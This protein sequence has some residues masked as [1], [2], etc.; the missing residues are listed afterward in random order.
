MAR[1][2]STMVLGIAAVLVA[3]GVAAYLLVGRFDLGPFAAGRASAA[4]GR[5]VT[6]A[7][8][9]VTPGRWITVDLS[10]VQVANVAG[11]SRPAMAELGRLTAEVEAVSLLHGP[12]AVA[13]PPDDR[14][15]VGAAGADGGPYRQLEV[16]TREAGA[17]G[18][19]RQE[20]ALTTLGARVR[21]SGRVEAVD[22]GGR[23][24]A[25]V[26]VSG[27]DIQRLRRAL[28]FGPVPLLGQLD[29]EVVA[30]S[31]GATLNAATRA[32]HVSA[33][34][35]MNGGCTAREVIEMASID[36]RLLFR[37]PKG[38]S[39]VSCLLGAL[40]MRAGVGTVMPLR[41]RAANGAIAGAV[42][43]DLY[44]RWFDLTIGSQ[45]ASTSVFALAS[46]CASA[47]R[48]A[49]RASIRRGG[50]RPAGPCLRPRTIWSSCRPA[51][52]RWPGAA[53]AF[54][55]DDERAAITAKR[56]DIMDQR[57]NVPVPQPGARAKQRLWRVLAIAALIAA[58]FV[59][60]QPFLTAVTWAIILPV[61]AWPGFARLSLALG[62][63]RRVAAAVFVAA[64]ILILPLVLAGM[65]AARRAPAVMQAIEHVEQNGVPGPS[66][67]VSRLPLVGPQL[68]NLWGRVSEQG[69]EALAQ[70]RAEINAAARWLLLR[71]GSFGLTLLQFALANLIAALLLVRADRACALLRAFA[72]RIGGPA[73][74]DLLPLAEH[75]IRA[76][77]CG[78]IRHD[79]VIADDLRAARGDDRLQGVGIDMVRMAVGQRDRRNIRELSRLHPPIDKREFSR[80]EQQP[81]AV[82]REQQ[83]GMDIFLDSHGR[84]PVCSNPQRP[85]R[86]RLRPSRVI[87]S[88]TP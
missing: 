5:P 76:V 10:G 66:D 23:L 63:R 46:R 36:V 38:M 4:L 64:G 15:A 28:G 52:G 41:V 17:G 51:C 34:V 70:Y 58:C 7:G 16:R 73:A 79:L 9:H 84:S 68:D 57:L 14:R 8:L 11:G 13:A 25:D 43:F 29:A 85:H 61:S 83:A 27:A 74:S 55:G 24:S 35:S 21:A 56:G 48:S 88:R 33:V 77:S 82:E 1:R 42:R 6:I 80:I 22:K 32:A 71:A 78:E 20:L 26:A 19:R 59:I 39:P 50:R 67:A 2:I 47:A 44:R 53:A 49:T 69:S 18:A 62:N 54:P 40:D 3:S 31:S 75:T 30:A 37:K 72:V 60:A 87:T 45:S 65:S 12:A 86:P 81:F